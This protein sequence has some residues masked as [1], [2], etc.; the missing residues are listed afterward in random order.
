MNG[1]ERVRAA[2]N[3]Q[4]PDRLPKDLGGMGSTGISC[5]AYP[6]L[7]AALGLPPRLPKVYDTGQMLALPD[8]DVLDALGCDVVSVREDHITNAFEEPEK[9]RSFD[10]GGRL[11]ALICKDPAAFEVRPD[12]SIVQDGISTMVR[13]SYVFDTPHAGQELDLSR[14]PTCP[15]PERTR[16]DLAKR[17]YSPER[18]ESIAAYCRRARASTSRAILFSGLSTG[19]GFPGGMANWSMLC[20][21]DPEGVTAHFEAVTAFAVAQIERLLPAIRENVDVLMIAADDQGTQASSILPPPV[22]GELY[23][24]FYR[25]IV[26][27]VHRLAPEVKCFLHS[28]GAIYELLDGIMDAGFDVL[29]PIQWSGGKHKP[30]EWKAKC[31]GRMAFWG[32]G[33]NTQTTLP[34]GTVEEVRREVREV[35]P[36]LAR[37]GGYI[38]CAIHNLLAEVPPEKVIALYRTAE[39]CA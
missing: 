13:D 33:V 30:G 2:L 29:N 4:T 16:A 14:E 28:C 11:P 12:G 26:A 25:R 35:V 10:F 9:W 31:A 6:R 7:V 34:W 17:L 8:P 32:G 37:G 39:E 36:I 20:L 18:V 1:R 19:L 24:P 27:A 15:D 21:T 5:F 22:F 23:A 3:F 38:F